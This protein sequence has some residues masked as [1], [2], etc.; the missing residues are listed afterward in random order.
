MPL[1]VSFYK[2][3]HYQNDILF[4]MAMVELIDKIADSHHGA[5][6]LKQLGIIEQIQ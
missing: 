5:L 2:D 1:I 3:P 6:Y 4:K